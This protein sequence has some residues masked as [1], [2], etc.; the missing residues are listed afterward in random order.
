MLRRQKATEITPDYSGTI[1]RNYEH[2]MDYFSPSE[3][4]L[5][6][7]GIIVDNKESFLFI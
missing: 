1:G 2:E 7:F 5:C 4:T 6:Y 3:F